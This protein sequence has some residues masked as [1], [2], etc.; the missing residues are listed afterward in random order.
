M[1]QGY[2]NPYT[3]RNKMPTLVS[4]RLYLKTEINR[5]KPKSQHMKSLPTQT[6]VISYPIKVHGFIK[7]SIGRPSISALTSDSLCS[8]IEE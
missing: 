7:T 4:A 3:K 6:N 8:Y 1:V 5:Y 2:H